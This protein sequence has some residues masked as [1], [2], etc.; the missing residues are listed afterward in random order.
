[1]EGNLY[2]DLT[3]SGVGGAGGGRYRHVKIEGVGRVYGPL[4][5][6]DFVLQGMGSV[7]G[8]VVCADRFELQGKATVEG[9][10][11]APLILAEGQIHWKGRLRGGTVKLNGFVKASCDCEADRFELEGGFVVDGMLNAEEIEIRLQHRGKVKEI[12]GRHVRVER[13]RRTNWTSRW[14]W[15]VP[16]LKAEL[17]AETIEGDEIHLSWTTADVVRGNRVVI[18]AGCRVGRVEYGSELAVHP[19]ASVGG[20][21]RLK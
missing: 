4:A 12:G 15:L 6:E 5:C 7:S 16:V 11:E 2:P 19:D 14:G 3:L 1:M 13:A 8:D 18:G 20:R 17:H 9:G 21:V 10:V